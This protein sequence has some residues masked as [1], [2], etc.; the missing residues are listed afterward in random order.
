MWANFVGRDKK[1][2]IDQLIRAGRNWMTM[3]KTG[4][5]KEGVTPPE[6]KESPKEKVAAA[7]KKPLQSHTTQR[8]AEAAEGKP[9]GG[10]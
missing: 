6:G 10:C 2:L 9:A 5:I 4:E 8:L 1:E 7:D 3:E